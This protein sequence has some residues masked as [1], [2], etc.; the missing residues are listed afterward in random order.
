MILHRKDWRRY[1]ELD[2]GG[3]PREG[4]LGSLEKTRSDMLE[5]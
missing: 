4:K 1:H 2:K 5:I 3:A